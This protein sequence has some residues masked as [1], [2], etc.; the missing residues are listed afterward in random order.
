MS[1]ASG[2]DAAEAAVRYAAL[3]APAIALA[4]AAGR[5]IMAVYARD[6]AVE[7]KDDRS[8]LTEADLA[9]H[10]LLVAGLEALTPD[11]PVLSEESAALDPAERR[12]WPRLWLVDPLDGTREFVKKNGEFCVCI[13]LVEHG[14]PMLGLVHAPVTGV[15]WS[16]LAGEGAWRREAGA[17]DVA[18]GAKVPSPDAQ[19]GVGL[20]VAASRS[21][22]DPRTAAL[23]ERLPEAERVPMGSA[24]KFGLLAEGRLDLYPRFGPTSEWDT[25]AGQCLVEA[26]GGAV[27]DLEG[28]ALRY[29]QRDTLLN[30]DF[31]AVAEAGLPWRDWL[32]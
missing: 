3:R 23:L 7:A 30:G 17:D 24:L 15:T 2:A 28:R 8:P 25:A 9:S 18:L 31:I 11:I 21:H 27:L 6:F 12:A 5:A 16:A 19:A 1:A 26:V 10:R 29:N 32:E 22:L 14:V 13:A 4:E 20:R